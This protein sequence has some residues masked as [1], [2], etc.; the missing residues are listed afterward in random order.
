MSMLAQ[1]QLA[2]LALIAILLVA[3]A[4]RDLRT[5][6]I[7]DGFSIGI[8]ILFS[9]WAVI[10]IGSGDI[11]MT[12]FAMAIACGTAVSSL[13][14]AAFAFGALGGGDVKMMAAVSLLAGPSLVGGFLATT[15]IAGGVLGLASLAGAPIGRAALPGADLLKRHLVREVPYGPA[16]AAGGLWVVVSLGLN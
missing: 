7:S 16:I 10:G 3:G 12:E 6:Q 15:A 14:L 1:I 8:A 9:V 13:G 5:M 2:C 4:I 11:S